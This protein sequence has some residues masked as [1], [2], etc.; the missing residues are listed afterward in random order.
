[1]PDF[2][3][4]STVKANKKPRHKTAWAH[5][6]GVL[7]KW[8]GARVCDPQPPGVPNGRRKFHGFSDC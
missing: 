7:L 6:E 1:M 2:I 5:L 4:G 8:N 3:Q